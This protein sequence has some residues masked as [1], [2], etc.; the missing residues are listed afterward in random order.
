MSGWVVSA[1]VVL[2]PSQGL[3]LCRLQPQLE[4]PSPNKLWLFP[5]MLQN[6]STKAH[7]PPIYT[8]QDPPL[9]SLQLSSKSIVSPFR[10]GSVHEQLLSDFTETSENKGKYYLE[11]VSRKSG[12][13]LLCS[14]RM[15]P[16]EH[17]FS[18]QKGITL[19]WGTALGFSQ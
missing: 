6:C 13:N 14:T 7:S 1:V 5:E 9:P 11:I 10:E 17:L 16:A 15:Q 2:I 18:M 4:C 8:G 12:T 3:Q 19:H